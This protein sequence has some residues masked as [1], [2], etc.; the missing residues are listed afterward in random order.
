MEDNSELRL[1]NYMRATLGASW[2]YDLKQTHRWNPCPLHFKLILDRE[3]DHWYAYQAGVLVCE[4]PWGRRLFSEKDMTIIEDNPPDKEAEV[5]PISPKLSMISGGKDNTGNWLMSLAEGSVFS[6]RHRK[7]E[8]EF[9]CVQFHIRKKWSMTVWL[10]SNFP[11]HQTGDYLV[12]SLR[13]SQQHDLVD[14]M[15]DGA[16]D[17]IRRQ[18]EE[19]NDI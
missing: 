1:N 7:D 6:C 4:Y 11:M 18:D 14:L 15:Q 12:H 9:I 8:K 10:H 19:G 5:I 2:Y 13:F 3:P 17:D 16:D